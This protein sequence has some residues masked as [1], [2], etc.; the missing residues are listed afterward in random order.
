MKSN[1]I[2][3]LLILLFSA[4][5]LHAQNP[6]AIK[7]DLD[8]NTVQEISLNGQ[9][10]FIPA[11]GTSKPNGTTAD[12]IDQK[13][14]EISENLNK[15]ES[16]QIGVPQFLNRVSWWLPNVS[17]E[18]E[19]QE[20]AR[21]NALP[22]KTDD[23]QAGWYIKTIDLTNLKKSDNSEIYA[24][25]EGVAT[26]SRVYFNAQ[27]VGGH[28]GMFGSFDCRLTPFIKMGQ[29][30]KLLVYVER[31]TKADKGDEVV[32][33][34]VTM[35]I[36]RDL[37]TSLNSGMF[38]G[39][40]NGPRAK[41]MG[42]WQPVKLVVSK[43]GGKIEDVFFN[44]SLTGHKLEFTLKNASLST[45]NGKLTYLLKDAKTGKVFTTEEIKVTLNRGEYVIK[46]E[47]SGINPKLWSPDH[48]NLYQLEV[49]L[50]DISGN[51]LDFWEMPV[52]YRTVSTKGEQL[53]LN[54][55]PYWV[56]GAGM[57]PYG[58][59]PTDSATAR[60]FLQLMHDGNTVYTRTGCNTWNSLW[61]GLAD[62]IGV[63][64]THEG[65]RPWALMSKAPAPPA[66]ILQHWKE[67]Q[68]E[69]IKK[70]RN[71]PSV[72][73]YSISNEGLQGDYS[74]P[75]KLAIFKDLIDAIRKMDPSRP[76]IQTSGDPDV[77]HN[78]DIEDVHAY[79]GWYESSSFLNDYTKPRRGLTLNDGR[80]FLNHE[81]AVPY[82][83]IDDGS[84]HPAYTKRFSAQ[85]WVGDIGTYAKGKD[86]SYFQ[87]H[88]LAEAK[89][90]SEKLRYSRKAL[91]T[92][93]V[94]LFASVTWI[95]NALSKPFD[96]WKP[97][98]VYYG[99]K[100][101]F[102]PVLASMA[103]T[104]RYFYEGDH[105]KTK[106]YLVN[107]NVD[108][109]DLNGITV[110]LSFL[111]DGKEVSSSVFPIG[112]VNYFDV[113]DVDISFYIPK[114]DS[115]KQRSTIRLTVKDENSKTLSINS[116]PVTIATKQWIS[117]KATAPLEIVALGVN[118]DV[119][120]Q[121]S[122]IGNLFEKPLSK[123]KSKAD[124]IILGPSAINIS[125]V[126]IQKALKPGG[127]LLVL[128]QGK[129]AHRF[130][131]DVVKVAEEK[132]VASKPH[133]EDF[134]FDSGVVDGQAVDSIKGEFVEMLNW[135]QNLPIFDGLEAMDWKWWGRGDNLAYAASAS[136]RIDIKNPKVLPI[137]RYL[138]P[139]FYWSGDLQK[140]YDAKIGYP[141]FAVKE[142]WGNVIICDLTI[143]NAIKYDPRAA[144]T[145]VNLITEP[146]GK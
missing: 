78:A 82:S 46:A 88:I 40:G 49:T 119:K 121:I 33:V 17:N 25:F 129:A 130:I 36:T 90:K 59:K 84:V 79:W 63:G 98:P 64:V 72:M 29:K 12:F 113:K 73:V 8:K 143:S 114:I 57:P 50:T 32:S 109:K 89:L 3:S 135:K 22:F 123:I 42:I 27:Y 125:K 7:I 99:V 54:G 76:I 117:K 100:E 41:F 93:G 101:A 11:K 35:P 107:D 110:N 81:S 141:V 5:Q 38:G 134:M 18:F 65:I 69:V 31:G 21:V 74:N 108:F 30:N 94:L 19:A 80:P 44:P 87:D 102:E 55:R 122:N 39:F 126:E 86:V 23:L 105:V 71:H 92:A 66:T 70:Y 77:D 28:L 96:Q 124:V 51:K 61:Y 52:G 120:N 2:K 97:F 137:G 83:M 14:F 144:K 95:Q 115:A 142:D 15:I 34:A 53:Y 104:Q 13:A 145:L 106:I 43:V 103:T 136:H 131:L 116:Y 56:R 1:Y 26:V 91:P 24:N 37:L 111:I 139:H 62:E 9:W 48:P 67:E 127:R 68:L 60:G 58:Y 45:V 133:L 118:E 140:M 4:F 16:F 132:S 10:D 138:A 47:K 146:F 6:S 85:S 20:T 75:V 128:Q 112:N